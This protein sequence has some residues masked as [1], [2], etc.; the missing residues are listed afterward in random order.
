[1]KHLLLIVLVAAFVSC[2]KDTTPPPT[3]TT[4][5]GFLTNLKQACY[6]GKVHGIWYNGIASG[7]DSNYVEAT[8]NVTVAGNYNIV[9]DTINGVSFSSKGT[10][11]TIGVSTI[12]LK[13]S[14]LY[15]HWG[16]TP[17]TLKFDSSACNFTIYVQDSAAL[18][19][20]D[21]TWSATA[22][23]NPY[24]GAL[25]YNQIDLPPGQATN[26]GTAGSQWVGSLYTAMALTIKTA[27][28]VM[29]TI[30]YTTANPNMYFAITA[31]DT[32]LGTP[33]Q[34][35]IQ[36]YA[37]TFYPGSLMTLQIKSMVPYVTDEVY[38][39]IV[40]GEF[41]GTVVDTWHQKHLAP[42]AG[43]KFKAVF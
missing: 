4:A 6:P 17:Y 1:M 35:L 7:T 10:F 22:W 33:G 31:Q 12:Q 20:A 43:G 15:Q 40:Y 5:K 21:N 2:K 41:S 27:P 34:Y 30:P 13:A 16:A 32:S 24:K 38:K 19:M 8:V 23:G 11:N 14:G 26:Y 18:G 25:N 42:I 28:D 36:G 29:D 37:S 39:T 9:T 3:D